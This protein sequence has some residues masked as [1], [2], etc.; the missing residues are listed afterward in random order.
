MAY[1]WL[2]VAKNELKIFTSRF[3]NHRT[4]L[5]IIVA[6][7]MG[8][9]AF[10][11]VPLILN[12]FSTPIFNALSGFGPALPYFMYY[13]I[14]FIVLYIFLWCL[15]YPLSMSL[16]STSDLSGQLEILLGTPLQPKDLLFGKFIG[17]L[18]VYSII[19]FAIAPW[20]VNVFKIVFPLTVVNQILIYLVLYLVV[21]LAMWLGNLLAAF[22]ESVVRKSERSRDLGKAMTFLV[23]IFTVVI[24]YVLIWVMIQGLSDPTSPLFT[25]LKF[26]PS[27]WG[28]IIIINLFGQGVVIGANVYLYMILLIGV[29][30]GVLYSG[31]HLA[32]TFYSLE[33]IEKATTQIIEEKKFYRWFRKIIPGDFGVMFV[34]QL[35]Q[36]S[37]KLENFSRIAYAV[38]L[39]I[40]VIIFNI[41]LG[42]GESAGDMNPFLL[43]Y[44]SYFFP[45]ILAGMLGCFVIIGSKDHLWIYKKA[46]SGVANYVKSVYLV[47]ILYTLLMAVAFSAIATIIIGFSLVEIL[48]TV[49]LSVGTIST[50]MAMA[51][52]V[53]FIFP[54]FEER[55]SKVGILMTTFMGLSMG[56]WMGSLFMGIF[57]FEDFW[58]ATPL[59][60]LGFTAILGYIL[61]KLGIRKL[62]S[63]E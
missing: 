60:C 19:L 20:I 4:L 52:G 32:G 2:Q 59:L 53:A 7:I 58:Y 26:F 13:I 55:G 11:L 50:L 45:M 25:A 5:T 37:R 63:L 10:I 40:A 38:G 44:I 8:T 14:S 21:I 35:K 24:M 9:Y 43:N 46:P 3:R 23:T 17:R 34:T 27:T 33:P 16:Q 49:G 48:I 30:L 31:Y 62:S 54:T 47:N 29:T 36:F 1:L 51:I 57:I 39:S 22:V 61:L 6:A 18:P 12:A 56:V 28:A 41:A 15:T 42:A